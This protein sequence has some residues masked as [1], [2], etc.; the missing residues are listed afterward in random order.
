M[1]SFGVISGSVIQDHSDHGASKKPINPSTVV[2][3]LSVPLM[4]MV[5]TV[6]EWYFDQLL[7]KIQLSNKLE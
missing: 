1:R 3:D 2:M 5:Q 6:L 4:H 7:D